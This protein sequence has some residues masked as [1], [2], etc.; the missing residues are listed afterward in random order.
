[1]SRGRPRAFDIDE[2]LEKAL[3]VF[4]QKGYEGTSLQDLTEAMGINRP[5]LYAAF[6]NKEELF[7]KALKR[8]IAQNE[9]CFRNVMD[10]PDLR[11]SMEQVL[12]YTADMSSKGNDSRGCLLLG[13]LTCGESAEPIKQE[14]A[15]QRAESEAWLSN[16]FKRAKAAGDL[17]ADTDAPALARF[18][19]AVLQGMSVQAASGASKKALKGIITQAMRAW[20]V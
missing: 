13:S 14:L 1:M 3:C 12:T 20:P 9:A 2:A 4:W 15:A 8:Y 10:G 5:S 16:R 18:Y 6:G 11:A 17:P 7:R 19:S